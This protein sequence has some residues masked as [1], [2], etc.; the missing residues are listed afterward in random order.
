MSIGRLITQISRHIKPNARAILVDWIIDVHYINKLMPETLF[1]TIHIIDRCLSLDGVIRKN[2]TLVGVCAMLIA[3]KYEETLAPQVYNNGFNFQFWK[4]L[5]Y[6]FVS[7][8]LNIT[9]SFCR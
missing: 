3:C 5:T 4:L 2:L 9:L 6:E 1:L 7:V 8:I